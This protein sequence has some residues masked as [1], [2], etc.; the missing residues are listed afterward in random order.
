MLVAKALEYP[1][2]RVAL[3][4][5]N[6]SFLLQNTVNDIPEGIQLRAL[7]WLAAAVAWWLRMPE[8][9]L[10]RLSRNAKP[11]CCFSLAQTINMACQPNA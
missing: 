2:R 7:R 11:T 9:L 1:L 6:R 10:D 5:V 3:L 8:H 4:E